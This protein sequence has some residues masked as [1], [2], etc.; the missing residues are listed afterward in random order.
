MAQQGNH[1]GLV[2]VK[3]RTYEVQRFPRI[4]PQGN[5]ITVNVKWTASTPLDLHQADGGLL[6]EH[7]FRTGSTG[8]GIVVGVGPD[9]KHFK[10][11]DRVFGFAHQ[12]PKWKTHQEY[13]TAPEW[14]FGKV[15]R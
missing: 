8:A 15:R 6:L 12:E 13:A 14:V 4:P 2:L 9:V 11:G 10:V 7:P 3:S 1:N 5:E